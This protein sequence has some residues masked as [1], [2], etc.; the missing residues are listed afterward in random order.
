MEQKSPLE[1]C[2]FWH[3]HQPDY[4]DS[5]GVMRMPWVFLHAIKDYYEM[6]WLLV[7]HEGLKATFNITAPLIEQLG[8]YR[9]PLRHDYF[10][11]LWA[12]HPSQLDTSSR[13]WLVKTCRATQYETMVRPMAHFEMLYRKAELNDA[14]LIDFEVLFMLAWC[15][16]YLRR[17][18]AVVRRFFRKGHGFTQE[19]KGELLES[20]TA[21]VGT[22]LPF[23]ASL[24]K[25]GRISLST[26]PYNHPILP[27]LIDIENA[28]KANPHTPLPDN[29]LSLKGDAIEQ[30]E[31]SIA[32]YKATF[33][34]VPSG[35][36]PAEGAVD[37]AS[38]DIYRSHGIRWIATDEAILFRSLGSHRRDNLYRPYRFDGVTIGFRDHGLSDLIGFTYRFKGARDAAE[39]FMRTIKPIADTPGAQTLFIIL[40]GENAWEF[41]ENNA[42][43]F[44]TSLYTRLQRTRWCRTATM[45][46]VVALP[47][48]ETLPTLA[49]GSWI[50][51]DFSTWAG[52]PEKNRAWEL[53]YQTRRDAEH[54]PGTVS[55]AA[56]QKIRFHFLAAECSDWFW[57]Y[58]DDHMTEFALEFDALFREHLIT[59]YR[60]LQMQPPSDLFEP[61]ITRK[62]SASFLRKP[63][64]AVTPR[65]DGKHNSFFEWLGSGSVDERKLYST[66]DRVRGPIETIYYGWNDRAV[67]LAFEGDV[68]SLDAPDIRLHVTVEE[69]AEQLDFVLNRPLQHDGDR[70]AV[71]ER[72]ELALS[73]SHFGARS[74]VHLRFEI[75]EGERIIQTM[76][77][78]GSLFI[79]LEETYAGNWF[80]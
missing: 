48:I 14:E 3:M 27:L 20:L 69:S 57:W 22:I 61:V 42:Y 47:G 40:D 80:V 77:G 45:D 50:H 33:G 52:H 11:S 60:L 18:N 6:P 4:R 24:L 49:P 59:I 65:I 66:M 23:Y 35:F 10:L 34:T 58:G 71:A 64:G 1:L 73:R 75:V 36:W 26:T 63:Q 68:A 7:R 37:A 30:V 12:Q 15:G 2:F 70:L 67:V 76:P 56:A 55:G 51:G 21:F 16:N 79:D 17:E 72:V 29:P 9:E 31:R 13:S 28:G 25:A 62:S 8:L 44:F 74:G 32:L 41:F 46:E 43:D 19:E 54:Y 38:I 78:F 39:H 5:E 53:L